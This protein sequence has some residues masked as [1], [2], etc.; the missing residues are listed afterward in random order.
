MIL[1][2]GIDIRKAHLQTG[3]EVCSSRRSNIRTQTWR[4]H[5]LSRPNAILHGTRGW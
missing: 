1:D 5:S 3:N 2:L 4:T